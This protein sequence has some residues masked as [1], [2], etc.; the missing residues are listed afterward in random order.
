MLSWFVNSFQ[1]SGIL[2]IIKTTYCTDRWSVTCCES[3]THNS[4][5]YLLS[6]ATTADIRRLSLPTTKLYQ[7]TLYKE[8]IVKKD[9]YVRKEKKRLYFSLSRSIVRHIGKKTKEKHYKTRRE[10]KPWI[11]K[12]IIITG[13]KPVRRDTSL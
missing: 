7:F 11:E 13:R 4:L 6:T 8:C 9:P 3:T 2:C 1:K 12:I 10:E 5:P